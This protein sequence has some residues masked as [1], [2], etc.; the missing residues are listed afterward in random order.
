MIALPPPER[1]TFAVG[2]FCPDGVQ[3][4]RAAGVPGAT[5]RAT[6]EEAFADYCDARG[7]TAAYADA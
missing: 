2:R 3:G 5:L 4:Y 7:L 6:R 1:V